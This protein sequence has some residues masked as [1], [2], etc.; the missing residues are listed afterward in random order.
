M[1]RFTFW[2][3]WLVAAGVVITAFGAFIV[4]FS[5]TGLFEAVFDNQIDPVFWDD[6]LPPG[7]ADFQ[8]WVYGVLGATVAGWGVFIAFIAQHPFRRRERW[9]WT[10][11]L[12]GMLVWFALD[13]FISLTSGVYFN[14]LA[15]NV[16]LLLVVLVPLWFTRQDFPAA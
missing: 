4:F 12:A 8:R 5:Q 15:V 3:R 13:S 11:L 6:D 16:P 7:V 1:D 10:C 2:Q 14:A 9:A